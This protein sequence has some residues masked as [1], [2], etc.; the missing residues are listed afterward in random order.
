[1]VNH[2]LAL[3]FLYV[4]VLG[5]FLHTLS[6]QT[7]WSECKQREILTSPHLRGKME[8]VTEVMLT[9]QYYLVASVLSFIPYLKGHVLIIRVIYLSGEAQ[10][11][12]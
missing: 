2:W 3:K 7:V 5:V 9:G 6:S 11:K 1:M 4:G 10:S 8:L 12:L